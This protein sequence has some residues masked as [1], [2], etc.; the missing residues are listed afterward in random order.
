MG[1]NKEKMKLISLK[2]KEISEEDREKWKNKGKERGKSR[3]KQN[4]C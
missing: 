4:D 3:P 2:W 1:T